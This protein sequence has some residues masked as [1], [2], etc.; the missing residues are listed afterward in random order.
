MTDPDDFDRLVMASLCPP[1][2]FAFPLPDD[3]AAQRTDSGGDRG[4]WALVVG[5]VSVI[6]LASLAMLVR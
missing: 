4:L 2:T 3:P 5:T 6:L 1:G